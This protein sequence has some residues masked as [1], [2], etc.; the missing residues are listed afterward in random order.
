[1]GELPPSRR[2]EWA[3]QIAEGLMLSHAGR[4]ESIAAF[5]ATFYDSNGQAYRT[6][7]TLA[8]GQ[9]FE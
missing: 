6:G 4:T 8:E 2:V 9:R 5:H 3:R 7:C 1:V